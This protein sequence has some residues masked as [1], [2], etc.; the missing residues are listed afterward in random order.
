MALFRLF[1]WA[2]IFVFRLTFHFLGHMQSVTRIRKPRLT[3][4]S[5]VRSRLREWIVAITTDIVDRDQGD[6]GKA[7]P[8]PNVSHKAP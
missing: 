8:W 1:C 3:P 5:D 4:L 6:L 2:L 7:R